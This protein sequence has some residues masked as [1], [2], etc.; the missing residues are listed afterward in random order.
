[1][2]NTILTNQFKG[3]CIFPCYIKHLKNLTPFFKLVS[4]VQNNTDFD[5]AIKVSA[6]LIKYIE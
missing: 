2:E 4:G 1:M 3:E 6:N 5:F